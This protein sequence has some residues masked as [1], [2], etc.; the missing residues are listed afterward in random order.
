MSVTFPPIEAWDAT[1]MAVAF[2]ADHAGGRTQCRISVEALQDNFG[3]SGGDELA[4]FVRCRPA[5]EAKAAK[6][7]SINRYEPDGS[8]LVQSADGQ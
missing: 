8:I 4:A 7:I 6:L 2:P 1:R 5:I 3:A